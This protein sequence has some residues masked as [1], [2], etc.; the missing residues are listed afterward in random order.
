[1]CSAHLELLPGLSV[2]QRSVVLSSAQISIGLEHSL[3]LPSLGFSKH[4]LRGCV[5]E[6]NLCLPI[7]IAL[8]TLYSF[9]KP[10]YI[11]YENE[12]SIKGGALS[13]LFLD[14]NIVPKT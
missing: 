12:G 6:H 4:D 14:S 8:V 11:P 1:M 13:W 5:P 3:N 9:Q 7:I 2:H 10:L